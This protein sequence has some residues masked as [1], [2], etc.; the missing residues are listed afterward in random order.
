MNFFITLYTDA[1]YDRLEKRAR[2][3]WRGKCSE[4]PI[5]GSLTV[6]GVENVQEA[7]AMAIKHGV[8]HCL[9]IF[10]KLEG[11]FINS[12]NLQCVHALWPPEIRP[13]GKVAQ[14]RPVY[15]LIEKHFQE[16]RSLLGNR[17]TRAKHVKA[18]TGRDD[19]RSFMNRSV[20]RMTRKLK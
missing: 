14:D 11:F 4:G 10:P 6:F 1:G 7:E 17:W 16:M 20:D 9:E 2:L 15:H 3:A 8:K 5:Y 18:H 19:T 12:D 13:G